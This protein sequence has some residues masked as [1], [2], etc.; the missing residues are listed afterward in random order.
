MMASTAAGQVASAGSPS[1]VYLGGT[2]IQLF[3]EA[4]RDGTDT[5]FGVYMATSSYTQHGTILCQARAGFPCRCTI[6]RHMNRE[7][8][9]WPKWGMEMD[10]WKILGP[11]GAGRNGLITATTTAD[12]GP[13][14]VD[15]CFKLKATVNFIPG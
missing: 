4:E 12:L 11:R 3:C 5:H 9:E 14:L 8:N 1:T 10:A 13:Q 2:G 7:R 6:Q 15:G